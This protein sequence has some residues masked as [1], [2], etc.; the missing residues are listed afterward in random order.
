MEVEAK[1]AFVRVVNPDGTGIEIQLNPA[2]SNIKH[3]KNTTGKTIAVG[4]KVLI[5]WRKG[6]MG[7]VTPNDPAYITAILA[8]EVD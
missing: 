7:M 1:I 5:H 3:V 6:M 8:G 4:Q 2:D